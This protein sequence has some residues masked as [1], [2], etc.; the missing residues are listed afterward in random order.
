VQSKPT[1]TDC[2]ASWSNVADE[3]A[4][5]I[6]AGVSDGEFGPGDPADFD[7]EEFV[8][9]SLGCRNGMGSDFE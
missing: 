7:P 9:Q 8:A 5:S 3:H 2:T 4:L 6:L 1:A